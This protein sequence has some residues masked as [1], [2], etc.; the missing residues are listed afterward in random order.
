MTCVQCSIPCGVH[1]RMFCSVECQE[2]HLFRTPPIGLANVW[3]D[4]DERLRTIIGSDTFMAAYCLY[5][6]PD[7]MDI[8]RGDPMRVRACMFWLY[9]MAP[10][11]NE[12]QATILF[13][14]AC[15]QNAVP[16][17]ELMLQMVQC[18]SLCFQ[19][20]ADQAY[21]FRLAVRAGHTQIMQLLI[22][23]PPKYQLDYQMRG[24]VIYDPIFEAARSGQCGSIR[25][26]LDAP[27]NRYN[28]VPNGRYILESVMY[29]RDVE[30]FRVLAKDPRINQNRFLRNHID[31][32]IDIIAF[33]SPADSKDAQ[34]A[35]TY[36]TIIGLMHND[37]A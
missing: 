35:R 37:A 18:G 5:W 23:L 2:A 32:T 9:C 27:G 16:L 4:G 7:I 31:A 3:D 26:L 19:P 15:E 11:M 10:T 34:L 6:V 21:A 1:Q 22:A 20:A 12:Q 24:N 28:P 14:R 17:V 36:R 25:L 33:D 8:L 30:S 13:F 29:N